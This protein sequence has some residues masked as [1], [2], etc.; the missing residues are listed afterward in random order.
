MTPPADTAWSIRATVLQTP[1]A[2]ALEVLED[3]VVSV[4]SHGRIVSVQPATEASTT[5]ELGLG[6]EMVLV[7]GLID[8]HLHA[9]QWPQLGTGLDLPLDR[10]LFENTFP[11]EAR[12]ADEAY[13]RRVWAEMVPALVAGGTTTAV[14]YGSIHEPATLALAEQCILTGQRAFVGRVAMDHPDGTPDFY[15]DEDAAT[16]VEA[17]ARVVDAVGL[18]GGGAEGLVQPI[19]TPRFIPACTDASL[20]GHG[21]L[22][23]ATGVRVQTH[24][25]EGDWQHHHVLDRCGVTDT[26]ALDRFG[27]LRPH[28][29]LA[30]A[31][32]LVDADRDRIIERGSGVAHCPLSNAYFAN[33]VF[34]ARRHIEAGLR[35][36]LGTDVAA[37]ATPSMFEQCQH[38][39][40]ASRM[41]EDGVD[42]GRLEGRGVADSRIDIVTGFHLATVGGAE[43]LGIDAG[44]LAPGRVFDAVAVDIGPESGLGIDRELD[45]WARIFEKVVRRVRPSAIRSVWVDGRL[46]WGRAR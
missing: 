42:V 25:S 15:R 24:C 4:G 35:I 8:T 29:V 38:A 30:H 46:V 18:V 2:E 6:D 36:G 17:S 45:G 13:A 40:T 14:Y 39:V 27:L 34:P 21:E 7:P 41:L 37:G 11:L 16:S 28:A 9:P 33:A 5:A 31:T 3:V 32:H 22:A 23:A 20:E 44:L 12:F 1:T 26:T 10:W 43:L 19:I